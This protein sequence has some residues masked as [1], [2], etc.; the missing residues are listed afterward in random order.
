MVFLLITFILVFVFLPLAISKSVKENKKIRE[1]KEKIDSGEISLIWAPN[2]LIECVGG[3]FITANDNGI[4]VKT[5]D[6]EKTISYRNIV[7]IDLSNN[8]DN[9]CKITIS[10]SMA[11]T[12]SLNIGYGISVS[13]GA[14][15]VVQCYRAED[16]LIEGLKNY[17][18]QKISNVDGNIIQKTESEQIRELA[19]LLKDGLIS[20]SEFEQKKK[21]ILG[22]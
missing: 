7:S 20:E 8:G 1:I 6:T 19:E 9:Y 4:I 21:S 15:V 22:I 17:V 11:N 14:S 18:I 10:T 3:S 16:A 5:P 13:S 12:S 2:S